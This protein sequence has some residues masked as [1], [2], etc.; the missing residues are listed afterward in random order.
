[1]GESDDST[2]KIDWLDLL[3][4]GFAA[5]TVLVSFG[6]VIGKTTPMQLLGMAIIEV[7]LFV[8]NN[9]IGYTL[10]GAVDIGGSIFIHSFGAYFGFFVSLMDRKRN[11]GEPIVDQRSGSDHTSDLFSILGTLMLLIYWP[12]FNGI[13]A[14]N[15]EGKH[16]ATFNTYV[17][18]CASTMTTFL[19]SAFLG[20][21]LEQNNGLIFHIHGL[22]VC[23]ILSL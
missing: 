14:V 19:F 18:L 6:V 21:Y 23:L 1:M 8:A 2:I 7:P 16:R 20:R 9:Y 13:L 15:G 5:A 22:R 10:L 12:S 4:G 17:S 3:D 11:Y